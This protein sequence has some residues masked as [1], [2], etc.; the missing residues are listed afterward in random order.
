MKR[1]FRLAR[2]FLVFFCC[3][4]L[5]ACGNVQVKPD[6]PIG[7]AT[8]KPTIEDKRAG[9]VGIAPRFVRKPYRRSSV[10]MF[11]IADKD[12][13]DDDKQP[14]QVMPVS[15]QAKLVEQLRAARLFEQVATPED[16]VTPPGGEKT[17]KLLGT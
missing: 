15:L 12:I 3:L 13:S 16:A 10:D 8:L 9:L 2:L 17:L 6:R 1:E 14:A 4:W 5:A 11:A 7:A